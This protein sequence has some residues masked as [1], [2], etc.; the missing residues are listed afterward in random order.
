VVAQ[1]VRSTPCRRFVAL[2][3]LRIKLM[4]QGEL[5]ILEDAELATCLLDGKANTLPTTIVM[6]SLTPAVA[7]E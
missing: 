3:E 6:K 5:T 7:I 1:D 2:V 4:E